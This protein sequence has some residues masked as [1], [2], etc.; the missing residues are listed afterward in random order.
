[1]GNA[2]STAQG[3][4]D[5]D[6]L[7]S[8][9]FICPLTH[10]VMT[11]PVV[12]PEGNSY[13]RA[14]I[15]AWLAQHDTSPITRAPLALADLAPN[16]A[17]RNAID[18]RRGELGMPPLDDVAAVKKDGEKKKMAADE[19]EVV[20]KIEARK[21]E[22]KQEEKEG[23]VHDVLVSI[24]PP[25]G[26]TRTPSDI[27]CVIDISGSM[28]TEAKMKNASG[29]EE[30]H[31][32]SLLDVVKHAANTVIAS[33]TQQDRLGVV[34]YSTTATTVFELTHMTPEAKAQA[35]ARVDALVPDDTTNL[36]DGLYT[37]LEMLG[38]QA[39]K[40]RLAAV[41]LLT[42]GLPNVSPPRGELAT[43]KR[44]RDQHPDLACTIST[45]G[46]GYDINTDLLRGLAVEG[47]GGGLYSF[48]PDSSFVGTAFV[49]TLSNQLATMAAN[50]RLSLEP[51]NGA[52][53]L[54]NDEDG[55]AAGQGG[56]Q[57]DKTSWGAQVNLGSLQYG[58][59]RD[60][61]VRM[62]L[63]ADASAEAQPYLSVTLKYEPSGAQ[64]TV[65][66]RAEGVRRDGDGVEVEVQ[67]LR[68]AL[69]DCLGHAMHTMKTDPAHALDGVKRLAREVDALASRDQ[70]VAGLGEDLTGQVSEALSREDWYKKWGRH[71]LPA[72]ARAH[73]LQQC[74]NFKDPGL[75]HYGGRLFQRLR[76]EIDDIFVRLPPPK[77]S[78]R[79]T[80]H[81]PTY[82]PPASMQAYHN[83]SNPCF[84]GDCAALL[85]D[86]STKPVARVAKGD[87]VATGAGD[88]GGGGS[89]RVVCVVKTHCRSGRAQL[90]RL[91]GSGLL[92]TPYHPVCV[93]GA[94][95]F[96]CELGTALERP[97]DAV[98]SFVLEAGGHTMV[99]DGV[100]CVSLGHGIV[101]DPVVSHP[102]F[103]TP[104]VV[105][106]LQQ[107]HGWTAG[108]VEF[109]TGCLVRHPETGLVCGF[110]AELGRA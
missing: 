27:C 45:F 85:A 15:T 58:Q 6:A 46:F 10:E 36:W 97:C 35:K 74:T 65:E 71:Y 43:L 8:A 25:E 106:D 49:N 109:E 20:M 89:A 28:G 100:R 82:R 81:D 22:T 98:Y 88:D 62:A 60:V 34:V 73:L 87:L 40:G 66:C 17:L 61:V 57:I 75:Q 105:E 99:I 103:G 11:D 63:P 53:L 78:V 12:D 29:R 32:L 51:L 4:E 110:T 92:V 72:L 91:D 84:H 55:G 39:V 68:L 9:S 1:M 107:M 76:D 102:Y 3:A 16:R 93:D 94:W 18:E 30:K 64:S 42:D 79:A 50:V 44:Y 70:R 47:G 56:Q 23:V 95:R 77:P 67:R 86:G 96:P 83:S 108:L 26:T 90:V 5:K 7:F 19:G 14:A 54:Y 69:V 21:V 33:L 59:S 38:K 37:G 52:R 101:A 41:L 13:E 31:G 2:A 24:R 48:I 104:R 80:T